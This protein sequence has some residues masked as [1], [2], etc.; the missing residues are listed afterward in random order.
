VATENGKTGAQL[1]SQAAAM[2][3]GKKGPRCKKKSSKQKV[4]MSL[5]NLSV[6]TYKDKYKARWD[7]NQSSKHRL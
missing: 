7:I 3:N 2:K 6:F 1:D 5:A 4:S